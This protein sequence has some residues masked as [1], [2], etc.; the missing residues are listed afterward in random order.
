VG[1]VESVTKPNPERTDASAGYDSII[2]P[3]R[4]KGMMSEAMSNEEYVLFDGARA[5]PLYMIQYDPVT[6]SQ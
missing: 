2:T 5:L 3:G 4:R 6:Q 1:R